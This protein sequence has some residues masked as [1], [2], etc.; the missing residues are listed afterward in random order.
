LRVKRQNCHWSAVIAGT[1]F[2]TVIRRDRGFRGGLIRF[3]GKGGRFAR[4]FA[5]APRI[6]QKGGTA[7]VSCSAGARRERKKS[8]GSYASMVVVLRLA[9]R[10]ADAERP[11]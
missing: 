5:V 10:T 9:A 6:D 2:R 11:R 7:A 8:E 4:A 3:G 1:C